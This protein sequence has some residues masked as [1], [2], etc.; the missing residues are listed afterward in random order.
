MYIYTKGDWINMAYKT[1]Q[2]GKYVFTREGRKFGMPTDYDIDVFNL[3]EL[4]E[5]ELE[6]KYVYDEKT[7]ETGKVYVIKINTPLDFMNIMNK[8]GSF[9]MVDSLLA[10]GYAELV[11][12]RL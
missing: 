10:P 5:E 6:M 3:E 1:E 7:G 11:V 8:A 4:P 2:T 9:T 12:R